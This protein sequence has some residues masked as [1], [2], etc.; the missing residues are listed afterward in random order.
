MKPLLDLTLRGH[1]SVFSQRLE[2]VAVSQVF[3]EMYIRWVT[4]KRGC[5]NQ[6]S[7]MSHHVLKWPFF[8]A[9][10]PRRPLFPLTRRYTLSHEEHEQ[11]FITIEKLF[12]PY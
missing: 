10:W 5:L 7:G 6:T 12:L 3:V 9:A 1:F 11:F 4:E 8:L 2:I